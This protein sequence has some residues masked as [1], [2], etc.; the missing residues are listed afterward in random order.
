MHK[1][2]SRMGVELLFMSH[3]AGAAHGETR[4]FEGLM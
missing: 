1:D 4:M 2:M 3:E